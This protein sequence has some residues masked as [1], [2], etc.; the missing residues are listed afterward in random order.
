MSIDSLY[1]EF[2]LSSGV[3][4]D[5]RTIRGNEIF[6]A[7]KGDHFDGNQFV[8]EA[9]E[10]GC[11]RA[12]SDQESLAGTSQVIVVK[13]ALQTLQQLASHHRGKWGGKVLAITGSNGK[14]TTKELLHAVFATKYNVLATEGNLNNH[15]GV[16]LTLLKI[17]DEQLAIIEM[18][19]NHQGEIALLCKIA[20][21]DIGIITNIGKAHLEGFGGLTGIRKG[22]GEMYDYLDASGGTAIADLSDPVLASM[23]AERKMKVF[24]YGLGN[25]YDVCGALVSSGDQLEGTFTVDDNV[26]PLRSQL[27][28]AYNFKNLLTAA[29]AGVFMDV[30]PQNIKGA[31]ESYVP[32]NNRS[33]ILKGKT[34]T[35]ILD[36]YNANPT[37]MRAA[38][39][40]F[41]RRN[42][43]RK[44][45]ILGDMYELGADERM[46]HE[47]L[48]EQLTRLELYRV[49]LVGK[50]FGAF[51]GNPAF[52]FQFF[53]TLEGC[54]NALKDDPPAD[55]LIMLKGSRKNALEQATNLL[56]DC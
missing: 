33:Q 46:E 2:L 22:K 12:V 52:P 45:L 1:N 38:L 9:L 56:Q 4:T 47:A 36:A 5:T 41:A 54:M 13:D 51:A 16:P 28:G 15:I 48:L 49:M 11:R 40:E 3:T 27:F 43:P 30:P 35:I 39:E 25:G 29:A 44:M 8:R 34:N 24:T 31:A 18:G 19:A 14:T 32:Q 37:S 26:Y 50:R 21:P 6:F 42:H 23:V 7:L 55:S 10:K 17:R 53:D 20:L